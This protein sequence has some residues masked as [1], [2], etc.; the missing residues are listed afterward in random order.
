MPTIISKNNIKIGA[1]PVVILP[2][3]KWEEI[4][5]LLDERED[6]LRYNEAVADIDNQERISF[7][8]VKKKLK[9]P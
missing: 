2:L 9:L 4:Q 8:D 1:E 7:A 5:E 6:F 3:A